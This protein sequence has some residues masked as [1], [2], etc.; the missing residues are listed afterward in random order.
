[1]D[2]FWLFIQRLHIVSILNRSI[3]TGVFPSS[4]K[5]A[6]VQP[7]LKKPSL[8][9]L[10]LNNFRPISKLSFLSKILEKVVSNQLISFMNFNSVFEKFQSGFRTLHSTETALLKVT[11]DLL[12]AA[13]IGDCS[14]LFL[15]DLSSAFDTVD[16]LILI[17]RLEHWVGIKDAALDWLT[18]YLTGRSFSVVIGEASS[19]RAPFTCGVPQG[20]ILG[21]LLFS[22]YMLPLG[23]IIRNHAISFHCYADDTQLYIPLKSGSGNISH[24]LACL[25]DIKHWMTQNFLQL[26]KSKSE[27][28]LFSPPSHTLPLQSQL[29]PLSANVKTSARNLGVIF[30]SNLSFN[31]HVTT[32]VQSCFFQL[33]NISKIKSFLSTANLEIV[34]HSFIS[35]RLD[36]CNSLYSGLNKKTISRLQLIQNSA[37][38]LLTNTRKREHITPIL[39]ALHWLPRA[40]GEI[41]M[42]VMRWKRNMDQ[43][44]QRERVTL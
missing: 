34:I 35:S 14:V 22:I 26:N 33:R 38:R 5:S 24:L 40:N 43:V 32:A 31:K 1:M 39:A 29:G 6:L 13:D 30:D 19:T 3:S 10:V 20:S 17:E 9:P 2:C 41:A 15:L 27:I 8:D 18:S 37:A 12:L 23:N 11:N 28:I 25:T 4:L 36:Y 44:K 42:R 21:P 7:L 16:H